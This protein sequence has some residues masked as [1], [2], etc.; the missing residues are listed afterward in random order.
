MDSR[1]RIYS[2]LRLEEADRVGLIDFPWP[3]TIERWRQEGL[4]RTVSIHKYFGFDIYHFGVDVSPKF[5]SIV[6]EEGN[7]WLI[8]RDSYGVMV[9]SWREKS[10]TPQPVEPAIKT[11]DDF[12]EYIEPLLDPELP[13]RASSRNYPFRGDLEKAVEKLQHDFFVVASILGPFEY[14]R[15]IVGE[16]IDRIL[17][18]LYRDQRM[19][20][21]M[22]ERIGRF[23][24]KVAETLEDIGLDS[25]W[26]WD[27]L[28][29]KGGPFISP[30]HYKELVMPQHAR[31]ISTFR[32]AGKPAI[33]HTDGNVKPL[34]PYFIEAGF[35]ALQPL[36]VKANMDVRELKELY[37]DKLAF[38]GNIDARA[39]AA[40]PDKISEEVNRKVPIAARGGGYIAGSDHS[41]PPD[42]SLSSY[43]FFSDLVK[44][45]GCYTRS[46]V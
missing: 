40:G 17:K 2:L 37:G 39:L 18:L 31:V 32:R 10:G 15:H 13:F 38:I 3:E 29:Y 14:V 41:V 25:I 45:V 22:F 34:I 16:S 9:K 36:E 1:E 24:S 46:S 20:I 30:N 44:K 19:L 8:Y 11:L 7:E 35:T 21:Y 28:A 23:L 42:V 33:L 26:V 43:R 27:D 6:I 12:K 4:P 5:D